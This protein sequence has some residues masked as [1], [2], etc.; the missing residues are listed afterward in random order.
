MEFLNSKNL[1]LS[2]F[3]CGPKLFRQFRAQLGG[4]L[5]QR[6]WQN[7]GV[8]ED[9]HE[10]RVTIPARH[11]VDVQMFRDARAGDF[12]Q[13]DADVEAVRLHGLRQGVDATAGELAS[14]FASGH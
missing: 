10:V 3:I 5:V 11:D 7:A 12:A 9:R 6:R 1:C 8:G 4:D 14:W 2:V 13:V